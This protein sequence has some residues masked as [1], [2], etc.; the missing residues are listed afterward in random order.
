MILRRHHKQQ[1]DSNLTSANAN[2]NAFAVDAGTA[3]TINFV[4]KEPLLDLEKLVPE[5]FRN[6][7][8]PTD[9]PSSWEQQTLLDNQATSTTSNITLPSSHAERS[10]LAHRRNPLLKTTRKPWDGTWTKQDDSFA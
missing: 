9:K 3:T 1:A 5:A 10:L 7:V 2:A 4:P 6:S 8:N